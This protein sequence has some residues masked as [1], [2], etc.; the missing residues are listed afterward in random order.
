MPQHSLLVRIRAMRDRD[1]EEPRRRFL[2]GGRER[3]SSPVVPEERRRDSR[4]VP[5]RPLCCAAWTAR[6]N[7]IRITH[8]CV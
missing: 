7:G 2:P 6:A 1:E 3:M 5:L 8:Y 4:A